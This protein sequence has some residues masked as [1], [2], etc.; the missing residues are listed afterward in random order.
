MDEFKE[1]HP[2]HLG[3]KE[4]MYT[5]PDKS[6]LDTFPN[7]GVSV[8]GFKTKEVTSKCPVTGQPD[9][10]TVVIRYIPALV[11]IESKS[12]KLYLQSYRNESCFMEQLSKEIY[13]DLLAVLNPVK[14]FVEVTCTPRG[15]LELSAVS[16]DL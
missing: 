13:T 12:L 6:I 11:C 5:K 7:P 1:F 8:V 2:I 4:S 15:G 3:Q 10:A 16:G 14:L 9:F